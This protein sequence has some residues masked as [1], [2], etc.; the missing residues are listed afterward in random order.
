[1]WA[2]A[3]RWSQ[4]SGLAVQASKQLGMIVLHLSLQLTQLIQERHH[5]A[6]VLRLGGVHL[7]LHLL[8]CCHAALV[9]LRGSMTPL[10][11]SSSACAHTTAFNTIACSPLILLTG[12]CSR[13]GGELSTTAGAAPLASANWHHTPTQAACPLYSSITTN[14][15]PPA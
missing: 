5:L 9:Q 3:T 7:R 11:E 8:L 14:A 4:C 1:M 10:Q 15:V 6:F 13:R 2:A 12:C